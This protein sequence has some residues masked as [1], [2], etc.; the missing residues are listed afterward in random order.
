MTKRLAVVRQPVTVVGVAMMLIALVIGVAPRASATFP[1]R[2]G[3]IAF[4][5]DRGGDLE[6]Y[7]MRPQGGGI[8]QVTNAP[9]NSIFSDWTPDG[10]RIVFDSDRVTKGCGPEA[11][12]VEIFIA[13]ADGT[14][15]RRITRSP[16]SDGECLRTAKGSPSRATDT[17]IRRSTR[18]G[19][20]VPT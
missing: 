8:V 13:N 6:I 19:S 12:N 1:G 18:C 4:S 5:S 7:T 2:N 15:L 20:T 14:G 17:A 10:R 11:C 9:G 16:S 3:R